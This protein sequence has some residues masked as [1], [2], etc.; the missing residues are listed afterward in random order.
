MV[1]QYANTWGAQN[2]NVDQQ[3]GDLFKVTIEI[4]AAVLGDTTI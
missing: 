3:R 4:P 2:S 1:M